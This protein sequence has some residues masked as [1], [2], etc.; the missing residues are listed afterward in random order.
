MAVVCC[1]SLSSQ[2]ARPPPAPP[3][4]SPRKEG[5]R[6]LTTLPKGE[7]RVRDSSPDGYGL[8][9]SLSLSLFISLSLSLSLHFCDSL[10][11][12][13]T[14]S[15]F[16]FFFYRLC[17][18]RRCRGGEPPA[19]G[20]ICL[21]GWFPRSLDRYPANPYML[22]CPLSSA[23]SPFR[24]KSRRTKPRRGWHMEISPSRSDHLNLH[25]PLASHCFSGNAY[26]CFTTS[27]FTQ[28]HTSPLYLPCIRNYVVFDFKFPTSTLVKPLHPITISPSRRV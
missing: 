15:L 19:H 27:S 1:S 12:S 21:A 16:F 25:A 28:P 14:L 24:E 9:L 26:F 3:E 4:K 23:L 18:T 10:S 11:L 13:L 5:G 20:P 6:R 22:P 17:D 2:D 8:S 7:G